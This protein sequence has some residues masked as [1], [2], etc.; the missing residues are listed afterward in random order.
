MPSNS[1]LISPS[2]RTPF[3]SLLLPSPSLCPLLHVCTSVQVWAS[4]SV[5]ELCS[6]QYDIP[7]DS[8]PGE[9]P[10]GCPRGTVRSTGIVPTWVGN[11]PICDNLH[12]QDSKGPHISL[13]GKHP[14]V[15]GFWGSP[16]DGE[17]GPCQE[18]AAAPGTANLLPPTPSQ[19]TAAPTPLCLLPLGGLAGCID[20][21]H[22]DI[23]RHSH[24]L[25][26]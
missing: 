7:I 21:T 14:E 24:L 10:S 19:P 1:I 9:S 16:L 8:E 25:L 18:N 11:T 5:T 22:K 20:C 23:G 3:P 12:Q 26:S 17:L 2:H 6:H 15:D 4:V 13:D